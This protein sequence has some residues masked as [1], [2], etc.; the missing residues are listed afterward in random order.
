M[1][2]K[3]FCWLWLPQKTK[4]IK[5]GD[6]EEKGLL[7]LDV[8]FVLE[9]A[10]ENLTGLKTVV[11]DVLRATSTIVA[12]MSAGVPY[13]EPVATVEAASALAADYAKRG[14]CYLGGERNKLRPPGFDCGNSPLEYLELL[15]GKPVVFT[16][17]NGTRALKRVVGSQTIL[18]GSLGNAAAIAEALLSTP[19][20]VLLVCSG[21][22]GR[23]AAEDV[24]CAGL[25]IA[26]IQNRAAVQLTDA[27]RIAL[28]SYRQLASNLADHLLQTTSGQ[29][30][31]QLGLKADVLHAAQVNYSKIVPRY[32]DGRI[33][34]DA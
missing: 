14:G 23:I 29:G 7:K 8:A 27:A 13:I 26:E 33:V 31:S 17:T 1:C 11:I 24:L 22:L 32:L 19:G 34:A 6:E 5:I 10:P 16:T 15:E 25:I 12:A 2:G 28:A 20:E 4:Q 9:L 18:I 21:T 30:L 3:A